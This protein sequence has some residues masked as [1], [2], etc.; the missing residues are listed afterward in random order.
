MHIN[1]KLCIAEEG[2]TGLITAC[3][4]PQGVAGILFHYVSLLGGDVF[5]MRGHRWCEGRNGAR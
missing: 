1:A 5:F 2:G 3:V 4:M